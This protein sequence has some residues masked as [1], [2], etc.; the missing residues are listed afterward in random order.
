MPT[1]APNFPNAET[2][3][4]AHDLTPLAWVLDGLRK[5]LDVSSKALK[6]FVQDAEVASGSDSAA[7]DASQLRIA[8][9]QLH[10]AVGALEMVGMSAPALLLRAMESVVQNF[11]QRPAQCT[12]GAATMIES[13]GL[14]LTE[15]LEDVLAGEPVSAVSLFPQY[16]DIQGLLGADRIH[17]AD[18]WLFD[19]HWIEPVLDLTAPAQAYDDS[20]R[21]QMDRLLLNLIRTGDRQAA[22]SLSGLCQGFAQAQTDTEPRT[23]WKIAAGFFEALAQDFLKT[24]LYVK[25]AVLR[26]LIQYTALALGSEKPSGR[27]AQDLVFLC[28]QAIDNPSLNTPALK[29]ARL[30]YGLDRFKPVDY[31]AVQFGR[32]SP[33]LLAQARKRLASAKETWSDVASG[34][35]K[36]LKAVSAQFS[37]LTDSLLRLHPPSEPLAHVLSRVIETTV[38]AERAPS[39]DLAMEM[40]STLLYLEAAFDDLDPHHQELAERTAR[41]A[42]RLEQARA[43]GKAQPLEPWMEALYRRVSDKQTM[44]SVVGELRITLGMLEQSLDRFF[45]SPEDKT[46][47]AEVPEQLAQIQG[48][49][50]ML[51]LDQAGLA[52][53]YMSEL[54]ETLS[55]PEAD[56]QAARSSGTFDRLGNNL[57]ALSFLIDMLNYQPSLAKKLFVFD[58]VKGE[59]RSD[60]DISTV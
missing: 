16:R 23:F 1:I 12:P 21:L 59:L 39:H 34:D 44:G 27:L 55:K 45:R 57:G 54:V 10:Q 17:P 14:S 40:A 30:S 20:C 26:I 58:A 41:L 15:Y 35:L 31:E 8:R 43:G 28:A 24:D 5:S 22:Q 9:Q 3:L 38:R 56:E 25:R 60:Q 48:V 47:L 18:L 33:A 7:L 49:L 11:V 13:A 6:R 4:A 29:A 2:E 53:R 52:V 42:R 46:V 37:L 32:F 36:K 50:S 51:G 19:W